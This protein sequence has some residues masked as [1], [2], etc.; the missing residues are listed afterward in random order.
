MAGRL[1]QAAGS[2]VELVGNVGWLLSAP[3]LVRS[4]PTTDAR[5]CRPLRE[6]HQRSVSE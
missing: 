4:I 3:H 6:W 2:S 1:W 5:L